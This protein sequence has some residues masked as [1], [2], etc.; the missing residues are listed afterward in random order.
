VSR[1]PFAAQ[2]DV[3][4]DPQVTRARLKAELLAA[5]REFH[6]MAAT[7]SEEAWNDSSHNPGWTNG[8]VLFH[9]LLGFI[10]V[11]P[12]ARLLVLFGHLPRVLG[13]TFAGLLNLATP[14]FHRI[15]AMGPRA[16][17]RTLGRAR[18]IRRFDQVHG[19]ILTRL[20][21]V[22]PGQWDL[23]MTY[24]TRWDPRFRRD[25][26]LEDLF[27]YPVSHLRHH[28]TQIRVE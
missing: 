25:M 27:L 7:L 28:R 3:S 13:S 5:H 18:V 24:P 26:R 16:A 11:L 4:A 15:N 12:L 6:A 20:A 2:L 22:R 17:A 10:L 21:K 9:V 19:A 14:L 1:E 23:M 8:Q